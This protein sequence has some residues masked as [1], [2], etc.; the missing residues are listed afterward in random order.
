M[1]NTFKKKYAILKCIDDGKIWKIEIGINQIGRSEECKIKL[2][3]KEISRLHAKIEYDEDYYLYDLGSKN[4]T[5]ING[6]KLKPNYSYKLNNDVNLTFGITNC[7]FSLVLEKYFE[8][9]KNIYVDNEMNNTFVK[10]KL[11][12]NKSDSIKCGDMDITVKCNKELCSVDTVN[13][14]ENS[15]DGIILSSQNDY[16]SSEMKSFSDHLPLKNMRNYELFAQLFETDSNS[17]FGTRKDKFEKIDDTKTNSNQKHCNNLKKL[18]FIKTNKDELNFKSVKSQCFDVSDIYSNDCEKENEIERKKKDS[19][20]IDKYIENESVKNDCRV[21][22]S[23]IISESVEEPKKQNESTAQ[24]MYQTEDIY[25]FAQ[26]RIDNS[27]PDDESFDTGVRYGEF[28]DSLLSR[29]ELALVHNKHENMNL[30]TTEPVNTNLNCENIKS[31][32]S[33]PVKLNMIKIFEKDVKFDSTCISKMSYTERRKIAKKE[34]YFQKSVDKWVEGTVKR[35]FINEFKF[36]P[37]DKKIKVEENII[38]KNKSQYTKINSNI[39]KKR[40]CRQDFK[41]QNLNLIDNVNLSLIHI[42][43]LNCVKNLREPFGNEYS[44]SFSGFNNYKFHEMVKKLGGII[45]EANDCIYLVIDK[46][47][48]TENFLICVIRGCFIVTSDWIIESEK[49]G[50]F[51]NH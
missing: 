14:S 26:F 33:E 6:K 10:K 22:N 15:D 9:F 20:N 27:V 4:F 16:M 41:S 35:K 50:F 5:L 47:A 17:N 25:S 12:F 48:R 40:K 46:G 29:Q 2:I 3:K 28:I 11:P 39:L 19:Q 36:E 7:K 8:S 23:S 30:N 43:E 34:Y 38:Q 13:D 44:I 32:E 1:V 42:K 21:S 51:L 37:V 49:A 45:K 24:S 31:I 18:H